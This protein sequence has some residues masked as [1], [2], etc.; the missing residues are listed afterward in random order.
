M[1]ILPISDAAA[2]VQRASAAAAEAFQSTAAAE[3]DLALE[4]DREVE[5][6]LIERATT[7]AGML[8]TAVAELKAIQHR[9]GGRPSWFP[10]TGL[11]RELTSLRM[12]AD[13]VKSD[14]IVRSAA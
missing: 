3:R 7:L 9:R 6:L 10:E 4:K 13:R 5:A 11:V 8:A 2:G 14:G 12:V 1:P